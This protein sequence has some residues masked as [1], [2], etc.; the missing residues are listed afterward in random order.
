MTEE[1]EHINVP[2]LNKESEYRN[3]KLCIYAYI[4]RDDPKLIGRSEEPDEED[5]NHSAWIVESTKA[6]SVIILSLRPSLA[7]KTNE[8]TDDGKRTGK[9]L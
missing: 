6:A 3:W 1:R 2:L 9:E 5:E 4:R 8:I 7:S